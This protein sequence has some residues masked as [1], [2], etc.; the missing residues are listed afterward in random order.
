LSNFLKKNEQPLLCL[1]GLALVLRIRL[2]LGNIKKIQKEL[3][4]FA[5]LI[6]KTD[7]LYFSMLHDIFE[8][9]LK[10]KIG[11]TNEALPS[12]E[13]I[14]TFLEDSKKI[15]D[16]NTLIFQTIIL[17]TQIYWNA[18]SSIPLKESLCSTSITDASSLLRIH[19]PP[20]QVLVI[21][22]KVL[23]T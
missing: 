12:L 5:Q 23:P 22:L 4:E 17:L 8:N 19:P 20:K 13:N 6:A 15:D 2:D 7:S 16:K 9:K 1:R 14:L 11:K 21:A 3:L 18:E 10:I